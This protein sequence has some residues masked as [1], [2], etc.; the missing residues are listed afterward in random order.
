MIFY[1]RIFL[2]PCRI[3]H[4]F[5]LN[6]FVLFNLTIWSIRSQIVWYSSFYDV[7][8]VYYKVCRQLL[9]EY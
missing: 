9:I 4:L 8:G 7:P 1:P 6:V 3:W 2:K 5:N